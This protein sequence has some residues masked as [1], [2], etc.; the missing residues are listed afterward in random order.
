MAIQITDDY[1]SNWNVNKIKCR[2][3][4][5][6]ATSDAALAAIIDTDEICPVCQDGALLFDGSAWSKPMPASARYVTAAAHQM[7]T[8]WAKH[9][10]MV[11]EYWHQAG[12]GCMVL[13]RNLD[14]ITG[15]HIVLSEDDALYVTVYSDDGERCEGHQ[16]NATD[17]VSNA[18][19]WFLNATTPADTCPCLALNA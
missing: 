15:A 2:A 10:D 13:Q 17:S 18:V 4:G 11:R 6:I 1:G 9:S 19:W 12:G 14:Y 8:V 3:C 5:H 16:I 7:P